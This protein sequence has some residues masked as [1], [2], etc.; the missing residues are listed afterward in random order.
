MTEPEVTT[1]KRVTP[2]PN[3]RVSTT[4]SVA[5]TSRQMT[6]SND[7]EEEEEELPASTTAIT[8]HKEIK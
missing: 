6:T 8:I 7:D 2:K 3:K 5:T 1:V 4:K